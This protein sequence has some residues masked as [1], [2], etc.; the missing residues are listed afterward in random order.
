MA[1]FPE[2]V[3]G[4]LLD[5]IGF[6]GLALGGG[7]AAAAGAL[8]ELQQ[9]SMRKVALN[10]EAL[11]PGIA[12]GR[13]PTAQ[14]L[15]AMVV[16]GIID[17]PAAADLATYTGTP[18]DVFDALVKV[19]G[20]PPGPQDLLTLWRRH[21]IDEPSMETGLRQGYLKNDWIGPVKEMFWVPL[22]PI[23]AVQAAVENHVGIDWARD[24]AAKSGMAPELFDIAYET[25]GN[26]P[27]P[28]EMLD[29][30]NRGD[31][32]EG[33]VD[34]ALRESHLKNK[35]IPALKN[36]RRRLLTVEEA[37]TAAVQNHLDRDA[38]A[39]VAALHGVERADFDVLF[40][41]FGNPPGPEA[42]LDLW[43]RGDVTEAELDQA[44]RE[45]RLKNKYIPI[46]KKR[47]RHLVPMRT[48]TTLLS[49]G[50]VTDDR[51]REMLA[52][53]GFTT[54][55]AQAIIDA[56]H[57]ART[58][59][60]KQLTVTQIRDLYVGHMISRDQAIADLATIHYPGNV[61]AQILDLADR[62]VAR[63]DATSAITQIRN[64]YL[65]R[66]I[67]RA[68]ASGDLDVIGVEAIRRDAL[69]DLW[70]VELGNNVAV[71]SPAQIVRAGK[72]GIFTAPEMLT[73]LEAH[74]YTPADAV[75]VAQ[76]GNAIPL[77]TVQP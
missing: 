77:S 56:A 44:L 62:D 7:Q 32:G 55:D 43:R 38:A 31:V 54:A 59:P 15:A 72:V 68:N 64:A 20:N 11:F 6:V 66:R 50:A 75:I 51:A 53:L 52:Q 40:E 39:T 3:G 22:T 58:T 69:L 19:T 8:N 41:T 12:R 21:K 48:V 18:R 42:M 76:L 14:E 9:D 16:K 5:L 13:V 63:R 60:D 25:A 1:S 33:D 70:D 67:D 23:E 65:T 74:G 49:H 61:A 2:T 36:L 29:L 27:G 73:R 37:V 35:W 46:L 47:A 26:P 45:S 4:W 57:F 71:L 10:E 28:Q 24:E 17:Q 34:Q 30:W